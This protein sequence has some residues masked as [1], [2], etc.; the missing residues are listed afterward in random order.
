MIEFKHTAYSRQSLR[1]GVGRAKFL[2]GKPAGKYDM[3][4]DFIFKEKTEKV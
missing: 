1:K 2:A 3:S 4:D